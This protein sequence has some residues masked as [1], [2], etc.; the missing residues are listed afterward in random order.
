MRNLL[1]SGGPVH[2]FRETSEELKRL[3]A[4]DGINSVIAGVAEGFR[5][6]RDEDF[7]LVTV[8]ALAWSMTQAEK[9]G[10]I[11]DRFGF[12]PSNEDIAA[13]VAHL[14]KGSG[15]LGLHTASICFDQ[16]PQWPS[17]LGVGWR[18]HH[19]HHPPPGY[20][21][22]NWENEHFE[23]WDELYCDLSIGSD[24]KV[25]ATATCDAVKSPQ[26]VLTSRHEGSAPVVYLALGHDMTAI[27]NPGF[28]KMLAYSVD[29]MRGK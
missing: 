8:N 28:Q 2:P 10:P 19:S 9:Y 12:S 1:I 21:T 14:G 5:L 22:V 7:D 24:V 20:I 25:H 29:L 15:L 16:W 4:G 17:I 18:W 11:R 27:T 23:I 13:M 6:L 26:P 3:L